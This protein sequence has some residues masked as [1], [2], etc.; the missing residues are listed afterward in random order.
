MDSAL[1]NSTDTVFFVLAAFLCWWMTLSPGTFVRVLM[2]TRYET[3]PR[4]RTET[5]RRLAAFV[6]ILATGVLVAEHC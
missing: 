4:R 5:I 1:F 3:L 6:A 2:L